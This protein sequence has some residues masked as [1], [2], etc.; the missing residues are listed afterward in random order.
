[1]RFLVMTMLFV[2]GLMMIHGLYEDRYLRI[3]KSLD[4]KYRFIPRT[5]YEEQQKDDVDMDDMK[6]TKYFDVFEKD[7]HPYNTANH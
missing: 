2:G 3:K 6:K 5:Y 7:V 4:V 1:M